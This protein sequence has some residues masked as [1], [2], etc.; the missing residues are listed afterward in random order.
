MVLVLSVAVVTVG[1]IITL[2][3]KKPK[4]QRR[5]SMNKKQLI[6]MWCGIAAVVL[7]VAKDNIY[8]CDGELYF[9]DKCGDADLWTALLSVALVTG[10]LIVTFADKKSKGEQKQ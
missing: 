6:A 2:A 4:Q 1:L 9:F 10:G 8:F 5:Q 7:F 3:D